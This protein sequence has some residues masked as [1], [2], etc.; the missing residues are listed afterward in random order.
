M[1]FSVLRLNVQKKLL[2]I[3]NFQ[4]LQYFYLCYGVKNLLGNSLF[5]LKGGGQK[6]RFRV[7]KLHLVDLAGSERQSKTGATGQR[8][9]EA[10]KVRQYHERLFIKCEKWFEDISII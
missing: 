4:M 8:L 1:Q 10:T 9:K 6:Q 2:V 7:G 3:L 5:L